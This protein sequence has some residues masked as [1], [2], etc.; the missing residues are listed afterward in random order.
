[1]VVLLSGLLQ[2]FVLL[3]PLLVLLLRAGLLLLQWLLALLLL[4]PL[5]IWLPL[6]SHLLLLSRPLHLPHWQPPA[7]M[8]S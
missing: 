3:P 7:P 4:L 5:L 6:G 8:R 2:S 1:M